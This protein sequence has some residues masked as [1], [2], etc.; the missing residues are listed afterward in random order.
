MFDDN[1][2]EVIKDSGNKSGDQIN[3]GIEF[4]SNLT[5]ILLSAK[6]IKNDEPKGVGYQSIV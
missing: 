2:V 6:Q 3:D 1:N 5:S 4:D